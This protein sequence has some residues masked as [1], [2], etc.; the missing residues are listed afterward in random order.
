MSGYEGILDAGKGPLKAGDWG[1]VEEDDGDEEKAFK[2]KA[3]TGE[4][5]G[6]LWWYDAKALKVYGGSDK[7]VFFLFFNF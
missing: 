1:V 7:E 5:S 6:T 3:R 4:K 2:V